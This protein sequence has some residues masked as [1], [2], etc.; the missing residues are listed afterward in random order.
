MRFWRE[1]FVL[2]FCR[3]VKLL[4]CPKRFGHH[5]HKMNRDNEPN[6]FIKIPSQSAFYFGK[7]RD[8]LRNDVALGFCVLDLFTFALMNLSFHH[9]I[10]Y[11][12]MFVL[13]IIAL[14]L[15]YIF[16]TMYNKQG[17]ALK[18]WVEGLSDE[19]YYPSESK[20]NS[21]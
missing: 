2:N 10:K 12:E 3:F 13:D 11:L 15:G 19:A 4:Y 8:I 20:K 16:Y 6:G 18:H 21:I 5:S 17:H 14:Y 9:F 7:S 1:T